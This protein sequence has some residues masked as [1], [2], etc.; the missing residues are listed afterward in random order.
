MPVCMPRAPQD[1]WGVQGTAAHLSSPSGCGPPVG[2]CGAGGGG[3]CVPGAMCVSWGG[4]GA[5][6]QKEFAGWY[7]RVYVCVRLWR[8]GEGGQCTEAHHCPLPQGRVAV[9]CRRLVVGCWAVALGVSCGAPTEA[10][11]LKRTGKCRG[12]AWA[13]ALALRCPM[14]SLGEGGPP[15][16]PHSQSASRGQAPRPLYPLLPPVG[17]ALQGLLVHLPIAGGSVCPPAPMAPSARRR[18]V[19][20]EACGQDTT[21]LQNP[22]EHQGIVHW[23]GGRRRDRRRG[24]QRECGSLH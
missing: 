7:F 12:S 18:A 9:H 1:L 22:L 8:R 24:R 2:M 15:P 19:Q 23:I 4:G 3:G 6:R 13:W 5:W 14:G 20:W 11:P 21:D 17:R 10:P 16:C